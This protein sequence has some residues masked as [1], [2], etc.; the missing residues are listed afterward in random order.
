MF[1]VL[2]ECFAKEECISF[3]KVERQK[4]PQLGKMSNFRVKMLTIL[5]IFLLI[6]VSPYL[7]VFYLSCKISKYCYSGFQEKGVRALESILRQK[8]P[9][10]APLRV[11]SR[12]SFLSPL[13]TYIAIAS[14]KIS[15]NP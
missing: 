2:D 5:T 6:A 11:F 15:K 8:C 9:N 1:Y 7:H 3:E 13:F 4:T 10:L 14:S 12:Y